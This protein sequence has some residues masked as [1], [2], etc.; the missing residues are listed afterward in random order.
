MR[1][2]AL[3]VVKDRLS[4][5]PIWAALMADIMVGIVVKALKVRAYTC[6]A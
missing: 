4:L 6:L 5:V 3:A 2:V 1:A